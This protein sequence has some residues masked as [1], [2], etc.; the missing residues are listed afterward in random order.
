MTIKKKKNIEDL[1][2]DEGMQPDNPYDGGI[3]PRVWMKFPE[4][5]PDK[6]EAKIQKAIKDWLL[7]R[8][9]EWILHNLTEEL[10]EDKPKDP[11]LR[12]TITWTPDIVTIEDESLLPKDTNG[13]TLKQELFCQY[14]VCNS[15]TRFNGTQSYARAYWY[16]LEKADTEEIRDELTGTLIKKSERGRMEKVCSVGW[17]DNLVKPCIQK[18]VTQLL[19]EMMRDEVVDWEMAKMILWP[20]GASK[21]EMIKEYNRVKQRVTTRIKDDSESD[22]E[23]ARLYKTLQSKVKD[24]SKDEVSSA[25]QD[26]LTSR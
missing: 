4:S 8:D 22:K 19:N 26:L 12:Y 16:D 13:L 5:T 17:S 9:E 20:D 7:Y 24:M 10:P 21:R 6:E 18:R 15:E 25:I 11:K 1:P 3:I 23:K 14:Y 2:A